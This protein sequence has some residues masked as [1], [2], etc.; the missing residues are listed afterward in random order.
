MCPTDRLAGPGPR[1]EHL[2]LAVR[3][4]LDVG[5]LQVPVDDTVL[6]RGFEGMAITTVV[7]RYRLA[8]PGKP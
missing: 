6:V 1:I 2:D 3:G 5:G 8:L 4:C 7:K